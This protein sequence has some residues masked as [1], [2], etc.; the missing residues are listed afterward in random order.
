MHVMRTSPRACRALGYVVRTLPALVM[1]PSEDARWRFDR[2]TPFA[3]AGG[4][5]GA[6]SATEDRAGRVRRYPAALGPASVAD[7]QTWSGATGLEKVLDGM[8]DELEVFADERGRELFDPPDAPRPDGRVS[9][10]PRLLPGV[11]P[12]TADAEA[13]VRF[14]EPEATGHAGGI[15]A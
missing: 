10:P 8:R 12:L 9:A 15:E 5:I 4:W 13:L 6:P 7:A 11:K 2:I 14:A 1:V 3:L